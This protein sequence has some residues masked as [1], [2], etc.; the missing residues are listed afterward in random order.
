M[1]TGIHFENGQAYSCR[2][3][4]Q[5]TIEQEP[6]RLQGAWTD[7]IT[8]NTAE[9]RLRNENIGIVMD[10]MI[11][12]VMEESRKLCRQLGLPSGSLKLYT[13]EEAVVGLVKFQK[14]ELGRGNTAVFDYTQTGFQYYE[15]KK[16]NG[17]ILVKQQDYT[18]EIAD[19]ATKTEKDQAFTKIIKKA[20]AKGVTATVYLCGDGFDG[21]WFQES[22]RILCMGRRVFMGKHLFA[23]GAAY[24]SGEEVFEESRGDAVILTETMTM[25]QIGLTLHHHGRDVFYPLMKEGRPWFESKGEMEL[26]VSNISSLTFELRNK[27]GIKQAMVCFPLT[28]MIKNKDVVYQLKVRGEYLAPDR[29][30]IKVSDQG[31]GNIRFSSL[32]VWQQDICLE[33]GDFRE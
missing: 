20:L 12:E 18:A 29:C 5:K 4:G 32:Q 9:N 6:V 8:E 33:R 17:Q 30:R 11:P 3:E 21:Q 16:R 23:S 26:Y 7:Y 28:G 25:C 24:L 1:Q 15:V 27:A 10:G 19:A 31:F 13:K 22:T 14:N 2:I